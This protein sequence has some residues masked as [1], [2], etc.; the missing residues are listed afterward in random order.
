MAQYEADKI[1]RLVQLCCWKLKCEINPGGYKTLLHAMD[2]KTKADQFI[3][4]ERYLVDLVS[5]A[6]V[7]VKSGNVIA[8]R[9]EYINL[10]TQIAGFTN[11]KQYTEKLYHVHEFLSSELD[12]SSFKDAFTAVCFPSSVEKYVAPELTFVSKKAPLSLI[13]YD[14]ENFEESYQLVNEQLKAFPFAI[15]V[16]PY[17]WKTNFSSKTWK[18]LLLNKRILP[19][20]LDLSHTWE[21]Q[22]SVEALKKQE[23]ISGFP[24][25]FS[26]IQS[27]VEIIAKIAQETPP[28]NVHGKSKNHHLHD[29]SGVFF[30]GDTQIQ[31]ENISMRDIVQT[32][33]KK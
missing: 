12:I 33:H 5:D 1:I 26:G 18:E 28:E 16:I 23:T 21:T 22:L 15:W 30:L 9:A 25:V 17:S 11:W 24:G 13:A 3:P 7:A 14:S 29:N 4:N 32:I 6:N 27:I 19:V 2:E 10:L 20:W 31:G 8:R